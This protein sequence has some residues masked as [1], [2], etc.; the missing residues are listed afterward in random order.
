MQ[1]LR[2]SYRSLTAAGRRSPGKPLLCGVALCIGAFTA[3]WAQAAATPEVG[4]LLDSLRRLESL[5][6]SARVR[7]HEVVTRGFDKKAQPWEREHDLVVRHGT[8]GRIRFTGKLGEMQRSDNF[9]QGSD[10]ESVRLLADTS[11]N[12]PFAR[13]TEGTYASTSNA[14]IVGSDFI[15]KLRS[16]SGYGGWVWGQEPCSAIDLSDRLEQMGQSA[17]R[18]NEI[19]SSDGGILYALVAKAQG[20]EYEVWFNPLRDMAYAGMRVVRTAAGDPALAEEFN[21]ERIEFTIKNVQYNEVDGMQFPVAAQMDIVFTRPNGS[22]WE[23]VTDA[24]VSAVELRQFSDADFVVQ[25]PQGAQVSD[26]RFGTVLRVA[27]AQGTLVLDTGDLRAMESNLDSVVKQ[28]VTSGAVRMPVASED[29]RIGVT[30]PAESV[31]G[32]NAMLT[33]S[34]A[35]FVVVIGMGLLVWSRRRRGAAGRRDRP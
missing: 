20:L 16:H 1:C 17:L 11:Y 9:D 33:L 6:F 12:T 14:S 31:F 34:A 26:I 32:P 5:E 22:T 3:T 30:T 4:T 2:I 19:A 18:V 27:D 23:S 28:A 8:G 7:T 35:A 21:L 24:N 25:F 15:P 29:G 10:G 13:R